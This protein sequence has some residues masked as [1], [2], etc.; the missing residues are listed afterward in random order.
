MTT[1]VAV[2]DD[3]MHLL[4]LVKEELQAE[5][6]DETIKTLVLHLKKPKESFFGIGK[7]KIK[8]EFMRE[9]IDRFS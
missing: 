9:E 1:T 5:T 4:R 3:T 2:R 7:G 6:F 8:G